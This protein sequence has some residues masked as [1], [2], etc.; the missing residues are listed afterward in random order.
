MLDNLRV[1]LRPKTRHWDAST[2]KNGSAGSTVELTPA[3]HCSTGGGDYVVDEPVK[4][5][6]RAIA[7]LT[8]LDCMQLAVSS[9]GQVKVRLLHVHL[10]TPVILYIDYMRPK[11]L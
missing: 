10:L 8:V 6:V 11:Q 7:G 1:T 2:P 5:F 9:A 4:E 3:L